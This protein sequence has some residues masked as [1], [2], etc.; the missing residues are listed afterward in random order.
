VWFRQKGLES[1]PGSGDN[2]W[3]E[4]NVYVALRWNPKLVVSAGYEFTTIA[5]EA[6]NQH[7]FFNGQILWNITSSSSLAL[8]AG[9][10]RPGLKC[11]S[12][13]CRVFPAFE[14]ARLELV[15]RL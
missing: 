3:R 2:A 13:V 4:G 5:Q 11:I 15:V 8:F 9:G 6:A 10:N 14:G 7:N 12:G 1:V